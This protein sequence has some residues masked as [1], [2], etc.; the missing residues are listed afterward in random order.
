[1]LSDYNKKRLHDFRVKEM[2][3]PASIAQSTLGESSKARG[4]GA[5]Q[6]RTEAPEGIANSMDGGAMSKP[7]VNPQGDIRFLQET[8]GLQ[9]NVRDNMS[10]QSAGAVQQMREAE[11]M[12]GT[13]D[14]RAQEFLNRKLLD[15]IED[16]GNALQML[17]AVSTSPG[18]EQFLGDLAKGAQQAEALSGNPNF[19]PDLALHRYQEMGGPSTVS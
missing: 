9:Q 2:L 6:Y 3:N 10:L 1:L 17:G 18:R 4:L 5:M 11:N 15:T 14:Y 12:Q 8:Q 13:K 7:M 16:G 19:S